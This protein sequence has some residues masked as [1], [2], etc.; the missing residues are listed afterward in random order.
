MIWPS[1]LVFLLLLVN[2][3]SAKYPDMTGTVVDAET[4]EAIEGAVVLVEW[5]KKRGIG[6]WYSTES[7]EVQEVITDQ[8]GRYA[9][10]GI[11]GYSLNPPDLTVYKKGYICWNNKHIFPNE[12][13]RT[14]FR[15]SKEVR[16][17]LATFDNNKYSYDSHIMFIRNSIHSG[18]ATN[19]KKLM[20]SAIR[21]E[22]LMAAKE[23]YHNK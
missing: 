22:E 7:V 12:E 2:G 18:S 5:T 1:I 15:W 8:D 9:V 10:T 4:G 21:W 13:I 6:G 20:E 19:K 16:L 23:T 14:D 3:C 17:K 11:S